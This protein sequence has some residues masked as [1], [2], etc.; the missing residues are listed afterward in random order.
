ML[1]DFTGKDRGFNHF[2]KAQGRNL[3]HYFV[4]D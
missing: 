4:N 1:I 2:E 3:A